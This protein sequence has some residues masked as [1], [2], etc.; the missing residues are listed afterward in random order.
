MDFD[1]KHCGR[2]KTRALFSSSVASSSFHLS[3]ARRP[4]AEVWPYTIATVKLYEEYIGYY[5]DFMDTC[6][7][8]VIIVMAHN[9]ALARYGRLNRAGLCR[10]HGQYHKLLYFSSSTSSTSQ[11]PYTTPG[12]PFRTPACLGDPPP[13]L[14]SRG[15]SESE[16]LSG[17]SV[18][19]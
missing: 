11:S 7:P 19:G 2:P 14:A 9:P 15:P 13:G 8:W 1:L 17:D 16:V 4:N 10:Q 18:R 5:Q 3:C 6:K 12:R